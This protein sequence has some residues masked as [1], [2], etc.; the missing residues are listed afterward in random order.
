MSSSISPPSA[1]IAGPAPWAALLYLSVLSSIVG[2]AAWY[3]A[4]AQ[5]NIGQTGMIQFTQ[6]LISLL[7]AVLILGERLTWPLLLAAG[8]IVAGVA[9]AQRRAAT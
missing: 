4:L 6:P 1:G 2:Y 8:V 5:G 7:L 9:L 3:W